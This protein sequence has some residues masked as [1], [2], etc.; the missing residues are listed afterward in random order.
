MKSL[1]IHASL[2]LMFLAPVSSVLAQDLSIGLS[3][4]MQP[5]AAAMQVK[6]VLRFLTET[7]EPGESCFVFDAYNIRSIG[8]FTVPNKPAYRH[9]KA[10]LQAN[11]QVVRAMLGFAKQA[12]RP[13]GS[14]EPSIIGAIRLPQALRFI[15]EHYPATEQTHVLLFGSPLYDDHKEKD[16]T[17]RH[18][19]IPGDGHLTKARSV[20]PYGIKGQESLLAKYRVHLVFPDNRWQQDDHHAFYVKRFWTLFI[21]GQGGVLSTFSS[22]LPTVFQRV[23]NQTPAP[24]HAYELERS[25]KLEMILLRP[26]V[27]QH[28]LSIYDRQISKDP[29]ARADLTQAR[30]VVVGITWDQPKVDL[31]LYVRPSPDAAVLSYKHTQSPEGT[32]Y[33][34][35]TSSPRV[36]NGYETVAFTV[37]L[38]IQNIV[39]AV[40]YYGGRT[41]A[42]ISGALRLS[43]GDR[44]YAHP[45]VLSAK[46]GNGGQG[47]EATMES[48]QPAT[49]QWLVLD[50]LTVLGLAKDQ[51][52]SSQQT[53]SQ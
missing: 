9:A 5:E 37:P 27:V 39:I 15:G 32:Y 10:K 25:D 35:F 3:P 2:F 38:K 47:G 34:D 30:D 50:P 13:Q 33:K 14:H 20:T 8:T 6:T 29:L 17:M 31:D 24:K 43:L 19:H 11:K 7:L 40:N 16:F 22:D 12:R 4:F 45:F 23:R 46:Q 44:T 36:N 41:K 49:S 42:P 53:E 28:E 52:V 21:E 18:N 51:L 26:P 1:A 48:G